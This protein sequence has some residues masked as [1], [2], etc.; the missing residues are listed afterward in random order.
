[1]L[2]KIK[3]IKIIAKLGIIV[4]KR[5]KLQLKAK[6]NRMVDKKNESIK[7]INSRNAA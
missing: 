6:G 1:M 3:N 7:P 4:A 2:Y 5:S